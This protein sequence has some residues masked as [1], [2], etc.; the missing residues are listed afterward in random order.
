M[1]NSFL[2]N[3]GRWTSI[4]ILPTAT[5]G[6][7]MR[8]P[9]LIAILSFVFLVGAANA[10]SRFNCANVSDCEN[11][12]V[13]A[14]DIGNV[15]SFFQKSG[16]AISVSEIRAGDE[17]V[18]NQDIFVRAGPAAWQNP[19]FFLKRGDRVVA[20]ELRTLTT[21][22][23]RTQ[24][25]IKISEPVRPTSPA[26][27]S[28]AATGPATVVRP[29]EAESCLNLPAGDGYGPVPI[30]TPPIG[31]DPPTAAEI[32]RL[33]E[34][35][36]IN[37]DQYGLIVHRDNDGK[38]N[39]GDTA[40]REGWYWFGVWLRENTPGLP[41]WTH[42]RKLNFDQV[43]DLLEPGK[44]GVF[45]RHP[46][47]PPFNN[48]F[49][50]EWGFSRDQMVPLVAAMGVWGKHDAIRRLWEALPEDL[51]GKHSF[52][53]NWRNFLGQDGP[54]CTD[55][56]KRS[57]SP[58]QDCSLKVDNRSC[59]L[60]QDTRDCS[61]QVDNRDCSA[62]EDRRNCEGWGKWSCEIEKAAQNKAYQAA[63]L[64]CE[65]AKGA[66]NA[67]YVA[68]KDAC[69]TEKAGQNTAYAAVKASCEAGKAG[70]NALYA[71]EKAACEAAKTGAR[72]ACEADK[73][74]S[75]QLCRTTNVH[76][77]DLIGPSTVNL[78][79]RALNKNPLAPDLK[80]L[81]P[82]T[83]VQGGSAGEA[84]LFA[85]QHLIV[86]KTW[87]N[88]DESG[89][90]L[91]NIILLLMAKLRYPSLISEASQNVYVSQRR[92]S[93]GSYFGA[94]YQR[95]GAD[96]RD[97]E[98]RIDR[99]IAGGW[100]PDTSASLGAVRWYHRPSEGA[101]PQLATMYAPIIELLLK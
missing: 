93:Y 42:R 34:G 10:Q 77:G 32:A 47:Q 58:T 2:F 26:A 96:M 68:A 65:S 16:R 49:S 21:E 13:A 101:N 82:S 35:R 31:N 39:G 53:G 85:N 79:S 8:R 7:L 5:G 38:F 92:H 98:G 33:I 76:S 23:K 87:D 67:A 4:S 100:R 74:A 9:I 95:Y 72:A 66:Q 36:N 12:W 25:W 81:L 59:P 46:K 45:Y 11:A 50:K 71:G 28:P 89:D 3:D 1:F 62:N 22:D 40:Q 86:G 17:L 69:E 19:K 43:L 54:N 18:A 52:N 56:K 24:L 80:D 78:F 88:R 60:Q 20:A 84:E 94:Y 30:I 15:G 64:A 6:A 48:A 91:N 51:I 57:C 37:C 41:K 75:Y 83:I 70:Q 29:A 44:D 61:L 73:A 14:Q 63:K 99:G 90:D 27:T 97:L 55:I